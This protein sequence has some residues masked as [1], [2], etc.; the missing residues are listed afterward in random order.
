MAKPRLRGPTIG[1]TLPLHTDRALRNAAHARGISPAR[2]LMHEIDR[3]H[4]LEHLF[5]PEDR[6]QP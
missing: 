3:Q 4:A 2:L 5:D 1:I 6:P